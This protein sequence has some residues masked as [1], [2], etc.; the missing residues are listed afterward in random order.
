VL[1]KLEGREVRLTSGVAVAVWDDELPMRFTDRP[2]V[3]ELLQTNGKKV[4]TLN[5]SDGEWVW[6]P[7]GNPK[8]NA[9]D[10]RYG[11][12][13]ITADGQQFTVDLQPRR[14]VTPLV[15]DP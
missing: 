5:R 6:W 4:K 12:F 2:Q 10:R 11:L 8:K 9:A 1:V 15:P 3:P 7:T 14:V 13:S